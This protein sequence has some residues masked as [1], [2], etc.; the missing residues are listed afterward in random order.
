LYSIIFG[1]FAN[2]P[3]FE[4]VL[5]QDLRHPAAVSRQRRF[6][7]TALARLLETGPDPRL[8]RIVRPSR[9]I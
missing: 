8:P 7:R 1:Y 9:R 3:L 6:V 4:A 5:Q 2:A